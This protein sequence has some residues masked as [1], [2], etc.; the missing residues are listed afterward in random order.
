MLEQVNLWCENVFL[1]VCALT[2]ENC[3]N[4]SYVNTILL[5]ICINIFCWSTKERKGMDV[6]G[7]ENTMRTLPPITTSRTR[8]QLISCQPIRDGETKG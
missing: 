5:N 6:S 7:D 2:F 4:L 8:S 1:V 3:T